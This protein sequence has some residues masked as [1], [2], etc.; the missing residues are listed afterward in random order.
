MDKIENPGGQDQG[1]PGWKATIWAA[2]SVFSSVLHSLPVDQL[3][4]TGT[5]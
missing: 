1:I 2:G 3:K 5:S 4:T